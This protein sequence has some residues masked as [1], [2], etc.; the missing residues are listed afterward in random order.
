M[1]WWQEQV[2]RVRL[3]FTSVT[4]GNLAH[5]VG[6]GGE[7]EGNR[8]RLEDQLGLA[9]RP[10]R[11]LN[12][13]HSADVVDADSGDV[14]PTGDAW[15]STDGSR[16]LAIMVADCLPVLFTAS[17][18][19]GGVLTA[20]AHAGRPGLISGVLHNTVSALQHH[21]GRNITAWIG[22]GAC[23][24]CYEVPQAMFDELTVD[25]PALAATTSWG[26][27]ALDLRSEARAILESHHV[28]VVD[29]AGCTIENPTL[30]SHRVSQKNGTPEG[31]IAAL[32]WKA[33]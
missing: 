5:H 6:D 32:I 23:G 12:Q 1:L 27:P 11:Y 28:A 25:R 14:T 3:G 30:F 16:S 20:A 13:V 29:V 15:I 31:R 17:S 9:H 8:R 10:L 33:D 4:A 22:P 21:G 7:A 24:E 26:T 18:R 19:G 2:G